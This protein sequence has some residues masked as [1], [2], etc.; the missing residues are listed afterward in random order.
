MIPLGEYLCGMLVRELRTLKKELEAYPDEASVWALAPG[1]SNSAGTFAL[2]LTGNLQHFIGTV[3]GSSGYRR[4]R[5][6]EF[7]SR[8]VPRAELYREIDATI[9]VLEKILPNLGEDVLARDY[10]EP[11]AKARLVTADFLI[12]LAVH[13][14]YH[15]GQL[16][17]HRRLVAGGEAVPGVVSPA[18]LRSA[19]PAG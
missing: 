19:R 18:A 15:L 13:F 1:I 12:H 17:Y 10:P 6:A 16:D 7:A 2:H 4:N 5:D 11:V 8:N 3:L 14:G 9:A